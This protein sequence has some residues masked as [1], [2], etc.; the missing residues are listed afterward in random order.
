M[1]ELK[2]EIVAN[3]V[4]RPSPGQGEDVPRRVDV[5]VQGKTAVGAVVPSDR[6][7]LGNETAAARACRGIP[8]EFFWKEVAANS[9][10]G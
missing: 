6:K 9:P 8:S 3:A 7:A 5:P 1:P 4:P 2:V 10:P